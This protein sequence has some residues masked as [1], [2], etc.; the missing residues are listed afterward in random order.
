MYE[1]YKR[2]T[3]ELELKQAQWS[4]MPFL[5]QSVALSVKMK[6]LIHIVDNSPTNGLSVSK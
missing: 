4:I 1:K 3:M 6:P 5:L 2:C